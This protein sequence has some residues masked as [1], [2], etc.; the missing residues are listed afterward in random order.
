MTGSLWHPSGGAAMKHGIWVHIPLNKIKEARNMIPKKGEIVRISEKFIREFDSFNDGSTVYEDLKSW[1]IIHRS[2]D[3][4]VAQLSISAWGGFVVSLD[5]AD[6]EFV[7][8]KEGYL[9]CWRDQLAISFFTYDRVSEEA[10]SGI[11][12]SCTSPK[13]KDVFISANIQYKFC[14][15]CKKEKR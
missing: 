3:L 6:A 4:E 13:L 2:K 8:T 7:L 9:Q 14:Q 5:E 12:C 10:Q 1:I 15:L 11:Y